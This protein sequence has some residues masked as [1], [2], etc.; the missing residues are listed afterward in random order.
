MSEHIRLHRRD[1]LRG[2]ATLGALGVGLPVGTG[3]VGATAADEYTFYDDFED[4]T[5]GTDPGW[6]VYAP[7]GDFSAGVVDR[8]SPDGGSKALN[9]TETTGG[10]TNGIVGWKEAYRG[11][12]GEWTLRGLFY[13]ENA[14][15][16]TP[17]QGHRAGFYYDPDT[18]ERPLM[19]SL[20]FRDGD[21]NINPFA[22]GGEL[23]DT[24]ETTYDPGWQEDTWYW[25]EVSH[26]G[27][28]TYTGRLWEDGTAR[29]SEP[30]ARSVGSAPGTEARVGTIEMNG[31]RSRA[32][33]MQHA[34]VGWTGSVSRTPGLL[35]RYY[36]LPESH[37]D[38]ESGSTDQNLGLVESSLPLRLTA[39]GEQE[40]EQFDW[41]DEQY[42]STSRVDESLDWPSD[43][44]PLDEGKPGDPYHFAVHWTATME[45][46]ED[47]SY[48]FATASDDES[49][50]FVDDQLVVDNGGLHGRTRR[51]GSADLSA[52]EHSVDIY[53]AERQPTGSNFTFDPDSR[54]EFYTTEPDTGPAP[55]GDFAA[56][57]DQKLALADRIDATAL[58]IQERN[59]VEP[60]LDG[61]GAA[62]DDGQVPEADAVEA[63]ERL[64]LA[65]NVTETALVMTGP[66]NTR[67]PEDPDTLVGSDVSEEFDIM[68]RIVKL[69]TDTAVSAA[70]F[71]GA[72]ARALSKIPFFGSALATSVDELMRVVIDGTRA[73]VGLIEAGANFLGTILDSESIGNFLDDLAGG[74]QPEKL[75][76][77]EIIEEKKD[78]LLAAMRSRF[79]NDGFMGN[80]NVDVDLRRATDELTGDGGNSAPSLDGSLDGAQQAHDDGVAS[81]TD[82]VRTTSHRLDLLDLGT[83]VLD[84]LT[85]AAALASVIGGVSALVSV[86][87]AGL[88]ALADGVGALL[89][90]A[91]L[92]KIKRTHYRAT[93]G[94]V[95][96]NS[97]F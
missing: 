85:A 2:G 61:L 65:E 29:P 11:W 53:F 46:P 68:S 78:E 75:L 69:T 22:I 42:L 86:G 67:T 89:T 97:P 39:A 84:V 25:Y 28:G 43:F 51:S 88:S 94:V 45:V 66:P 4:G 1:L 3:S 64:K 80:F 23:V 82:R 15:L 60:A 95:A 10:G 36:N 54:A 31:A 70:V 72:A 18:S 20:G 58:T 37:P 73:V 83:T 56:V 57:K 5:L 44:F 7:E 90:F 71:A 87:L 34:F 21:G 96:G 6:T 13:T 35:G 81:I 30:N 19:A 63:T 8:S 14:P 24:V 52:G 50:V 40:Y 49:W 74:V 16:S 33:D 27:N 59:R 76:A 38:V 47:G 41:W 92:E 17:F 12:D 55:G 32:F 26:D 48:S 93:S 91:E 79:E 77:S 62:I 9:V